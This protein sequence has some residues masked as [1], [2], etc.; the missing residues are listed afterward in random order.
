MVV[1]VI[2]AFHKYQ[3]YVAI[4]VWTATLGGADLPRV[5]RAV[6]LCIVFERL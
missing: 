1:A 3:P 6:V 2:K 5:S 4:R